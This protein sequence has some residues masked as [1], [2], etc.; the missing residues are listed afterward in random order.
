MIEQGLIGYGRQDFLERFEIGGPGDFAAVGPPEDEI[1]ESQ[2]I[3]KEL[4][5]FG[6]QVVTVLVQKG[7]RHP[8]ARSLFWGSLLIS[9]SGKSGIA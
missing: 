3:Q 5:D 4:V 1:A 7:C 6:Q 2:G 9:S 8:L